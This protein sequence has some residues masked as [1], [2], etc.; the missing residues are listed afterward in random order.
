V[1]AEA[2][3]HALLAQVLRSLEHGVLRL[4]HRHAV[5]VDLMFVPDDDPRA[6]G[7]RGPAAADRRGTAHDARQ[8][9]S[10]SITP[11]P[12]PRR[13]QDAGG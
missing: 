13:L 9:A 1:D 8:P 3:V 10:V 7:M 12:R 2:H 6:G 5:V 11:C 4:R